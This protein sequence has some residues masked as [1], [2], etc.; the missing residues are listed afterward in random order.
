MPTPLHIIYTP[1]IFSAQAFGGIS[2]YFVELTRQLHAAGQHP[3]IAAGLHVN[4]LLG[5]LPGSTVTGLYLRRG[6]N[7]IP[8]LRVRI[9]RGVCRYLIARDPRTVVHQTYYGDPGY[10]GSRPLVLTVY[11]LIHHLYRR[12]Y[13]ERDE[14]CDPAVTHQRRNCERADHI[15]AISQTTKDDLVRLFA[16]DPVKVTVIHL[17]NSLPPPE[18]SRPEDTPATNRV[19]PGGGEYLLFVG[20]RS[21]YK[22]FDAVLAAFSRSM[23]LRQRFKL[24]CFGGGL[25]SGT[26]HRRIAELGLEGAVIERHGG[27][28]V[29]ARCYR[30]AAAFVYPSQYE[31]FGLPLL[32]AMGQGCPVLASTGG[33]LPE[34]AGDA[35]AYFDPT[36]IDSIQHTMEQTLADPARPALLV[37]RGHDRVQRFGWDKCARETLEVYRRLLG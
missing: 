18:E 6:I 20:Q 32:E 13:P 31:G 30:E 21:G 27:D 22:N 14:D 12:Q 35:A 37:A 1:E 19:L 8:N 9:N 2:R 15:I 17:G 28:D 4:R 5:E 10:L 3:R 36:D 29:L 24:L 16:V 34:V 23:P 25:L 7:R 26:E 33:S 11:D